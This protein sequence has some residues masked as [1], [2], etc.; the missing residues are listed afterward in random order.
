MYVGDID[1]SIVCACRALVS[2]NMSQVLT[3]C[4]VWYSTG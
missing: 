2:I 1:Y 3:V 4:V